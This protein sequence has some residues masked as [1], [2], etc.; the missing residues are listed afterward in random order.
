[1]FNNQ[2]NKGSKPFNFNNDKNKSQRSH[3]FNKNNL[4]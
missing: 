3:S 4:Y 2:N 1:M